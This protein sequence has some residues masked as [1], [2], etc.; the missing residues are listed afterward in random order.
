LGG[1][2]D[3][4]A[5][6]DILADLITLPVEPLHARGQPPSWL[7]RVRQS[8][9]EEPDRLSIAALAAESGVHRAHLSRE[10]RRFYGVSPSLFRHRLRSARAIEVDHTIPAPLS[11]LA[12]DNGFFD[13][14]HFTRR[15][16]AE[17]GIPPRRLRAMFG[18]ATIVQ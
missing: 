9:Q 18:R 12:Q 7:A 17:T 14:A 13:Q 8:V 15:I 5:A 2:T 10:F 16:A 1:T 11:A 6:S 4:A 3:E